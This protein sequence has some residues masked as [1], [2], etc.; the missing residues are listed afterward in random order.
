MEE[1]HVQ[2]DWEQLKEI[3]MDAAEETKV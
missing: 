3:I 1:S 2:G